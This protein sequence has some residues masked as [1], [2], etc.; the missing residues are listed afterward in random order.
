MTRMILFP[1]RSGQLI[2]GSSPRKRQDLTA[3]PIPQNN[4]RKPMAEGIARGDRALGTPTLIIDDA[5]RMKSPSRARKQPT[6][7]ST[8]LNVFTPNSEYRDSRGYSAKEPRCQKTF[9]AEGQ[10]PGLYPHLH[11]YPFSTPLPLSHLV[12]QQFRFG[13]YN[14]RAKLNPLR[15]SHNHP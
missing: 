5:Y 7:I 15:H 1:S 2:L 3:S 12:A 4:M 8:G 13:K 6:A 11:Q 9:S 10:T 14:Y